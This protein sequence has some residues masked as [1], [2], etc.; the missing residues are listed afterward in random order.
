M[1]KKKKQPKKVEFSKVILIASFV[2]NLCVII[3]ACVMIVKTYDLTPLMYLI[4]A[5]A[6]DV[7]TGL[8]FYYNKAKAENKIKL[9]K[10]HKVEP[11]ESSFD[12]Y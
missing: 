4:P 12:V 7:A 10:K 11:S 6:A 2:V 9:M 8:G 5:T 1:G 3:F